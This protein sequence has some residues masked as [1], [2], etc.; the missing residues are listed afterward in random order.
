MIYFFQQSGH[1]Q[2]GARAQND[3]NSYF[4]EFFG[5]MG[6]SARAI[7]VDQFPTGDDH[8]VLF[9]GVGDFS[10]ASD[11]IKNF[12]QGG[13]TVIAL[14]TELPQKITGLRKVGCIGADSEYSVSAHLKP[15][16]KG[17]SL[18]GGEVRLPVIGDIRH[19]VFA[20]KEVDYLAVSC[21]HDIPLL[22]RNR[23][24]KGWVYTF[25]FSL[26]QTLW[27]KTQ[28]KPVY[29][30]VDGDGYC[31]S[32]D[33]H[34][35]D[36]SDDCKLP[37]LD[38]YMHAVERIL[39]ET[40][41]VP[42]LHQIPPESGKPCDY[43]MHF[44]GDED[45]CGEQMYEANRELK[46]RGVPYHVHLQPLDYK[47]FTIDKRKFDELRS[48]GLELSLH[49]DFITN[50]TYK[51]DFSALK[52]QADLYKRIFGVT[53]QT[54]NSHWIIYNGFGE[55]ARWYSKLGFTGTIRQLGMKSDL[56]D[57]NAMNDYGFVF[58]TSYP[59]Q[60]LD[61]ARYHN[62]QTGIYDLKMLFYE[63]RIDSQEDVAR[64]DKFMEMSNEYA[65]VVNIFI[66]PVYLVEDKSRVLPAVDR[67]LAHTEG[68]RCRLMYTDELTKWWRARAE[69]KLA[70]RSHGVYDAD[71]KTDLVIKLPYDFAVTVD[72]QTVEGYCKTVA[73]TQV[74]L[75]AVSAGKHEIRVIAK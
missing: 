35:V 26:L 30:D 27:Y 43:C 11:A 5:I 49:F 66:H 21:E 61:D 48:Q 24:G 39:W 64:I 18:F 42:L 46:S 60:S 63:P 15:T 71:F 19:C 58:G 17:V 68:K 9:I 50:K 52:E 8:A 56:S 32:F 72:G 16:E 6:C 10:F 34:I 69:S 44:A 29:R 1:F 25:T 36:W 45:L 23:F 7:G 40:D 51:Y 57:I 3:A 62:R 70:E 31:R 54:A 2:K 33:S 37:A 75:F 4:N 73:G 13:G 12:V 22:A 14:G 65:L 28:G 20:D 74:A 47:G 55:T 41:R 59:T 67:I 53:P 38:I